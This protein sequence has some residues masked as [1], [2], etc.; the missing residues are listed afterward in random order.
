M[1]LKLLSRACTPLLLLP[2][3][4]FGGMYTDAHW[5]HLTLHSVVMEPALE[6]FRLAYDRGA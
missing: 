3:A 1:L 2:A 4:Q 6:E 5:K